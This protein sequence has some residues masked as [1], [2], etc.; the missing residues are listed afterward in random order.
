VLRFHSG[1]ADGRNGTSGL[2]DGGYRVSAVNGSSDLINIRQVNGSL[3]SH[4]QSPYAAIDFDL[5]PEWTWK[6]E[7]T[8]YGYGEGSPVGPTLPRNFRGNVSTIAVHYAF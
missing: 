7:F 5:M 4:F 6:A 1:T 8:H 2:R 3:Q